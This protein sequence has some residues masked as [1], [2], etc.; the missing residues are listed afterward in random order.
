[1]VWVK[2]ATS[3]DKGYEV[4]RRDIKEKVVSILETQYF[5]TNFYY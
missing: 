2:K 4:T 5:K 3:D 1:M